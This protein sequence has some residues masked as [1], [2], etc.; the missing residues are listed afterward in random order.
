MLPSLE[1][2]LERGDWKESHRSVLL[3]GL[4]PVYSF[5]FL[6]LERF[7]PLLPWSLRTCRGSQ[8]PPPPQ[9]QWS[10]GGL[11]APSTQSHSQLCPDLSQ[12]RDTKQHQQ[13]GKPRGKVWRDQTQASRV[14]SPWSHVFTSSSNELWQQ[15][16]NGVYREARWRLGNRVFIPG[17]GHVGAL[18]LART[19]TP[20]SQK[21]SWC[22]A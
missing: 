13:R 17:A 15:T 1:R 2:H 22:S 11:T 19:K 7:L 4:P 6:S 3:S 16:W 21:E 9:A 12:W 14:L 5:N 20:D 18:C 10:P 8:R